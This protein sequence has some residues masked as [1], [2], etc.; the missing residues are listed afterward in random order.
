MDKKVK[1]ERLYFAEGWYKAKNLY[2]KRDKVDLEINDNQSDYWY[3][4]VIED[5][6]IDV[7]KM[8][9]IKNRLTV[10]RGK[11]I[12]MY[13]Y[14]Y[15]NHYNPTNSHFHLDICNLKN[16]KKILTFKNFYRNNQHLYENL[17]TYITHEFVYILNE[18]LVY[19]GLS[20][21]Y[22]KEANMKA[23]D[24]LKDIRADLTTKKLLVDNKKKARFD[25]VHG[26]KD[27]HKT[28]ILDKETRLE[29]INDFNDYESN[30][31]IIIDKYLEES[32]IELI[33]F[34]QKEFEG[35]Q[36]KYFFNLLGI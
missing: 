28:G 17:Y 13:K 9:D 4:D 26:N 15:M 22:S 23:L 1:P 29:V 10:H 16:L 8:L 6:V 34:V 11:A 18:D 31:D 14:F 20:E 27:Y 30:I 3:M 21:N 24:V 33:E 36:L 2:A 35:K 25:W 32:K 7:Y 12:K 5:I 19:F